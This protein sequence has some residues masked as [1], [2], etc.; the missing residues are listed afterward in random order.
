MDSILLFIRAAS[1]FAPCKFSSKPF[2][3]LLCSYQRLTFECFVKS[4]PHSTMVAIVGRM[5]KSAMV[6]FSPAIHLEFSKNVSIT[7]RL[8]V[9]E[10]RAA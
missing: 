1:S 5:E 3:D 7:R 9:T 10:S 8:S 6:S 2:K 4:Y